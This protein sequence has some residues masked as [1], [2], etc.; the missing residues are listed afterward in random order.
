MWWDVVGAD[1]EGGA[2]VSDREPFA[3][4]DKW[5]HEPCPTRG[6]TLCTITDRAHRHMAA[7]MVPKLTLTVTGGDKS[8]SVLGAVEAL[9]AHDDDGSTKFVTS[10]NDTHLAL[11]PRVTP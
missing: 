11:P 6:A 2:A 7:H 3:W 5:T 1:G 4:V 9:G 8:W 10:E